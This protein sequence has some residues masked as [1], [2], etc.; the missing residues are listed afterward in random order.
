MAQQRTLAT[1]AAAHNDE[2]LPGLDAER[3]IALDHETPVGHGQIVD[4]NARFV[5]GIVWPLLIR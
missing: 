1:P 2:D 5:G 4:R 3:Q